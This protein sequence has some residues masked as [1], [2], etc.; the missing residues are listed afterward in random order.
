MKICLVVA[1]S[2][3]TGV[4]SVVFSLARGLRHAGVQVTVVLLSEGP[5]AD[6][7]CAYAIDT[8]VIPVRH[9][10]DILKTVALGRFFKT[11]K[12]D[13]I[14]A[15]GARASFFSSLAAV[16]CKASTLVATI[17]ELSDG[18]F[19]S[20]FVRS[21]ENAI[22]RWACKKY[23]AVSKSVEEDALAC[24][25]L[26][27]SKA[28]LIPNCLPDIFLERVSADCPGQK[29]Q[30]DTGMQDDLVVGIV[31]RLDVIKGHKYIIQ[32]WPSVML[33]FPSAQ[34]KVAGTGPL[35]HELE[36]LSLS[37][38]IRPMV[39]FL[40]S[41]EDMVQFY[42]TINLLVVPSLSESFGMTILEAM[43]CGV[44]VIASDVGGVSEIV[45]HEWNGLLVAGESP[46]AL[47]Q[48][49][50]RL[51]SDHNLRRGIISNGLTTVGPYKED[52]FIHRHMELY[53]SLIQGN[54]LEK[55]PEMRWGR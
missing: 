25:G 4:E 48:A 52:A 36:K 23:V 10:F 20:A 19:R 47:A 12:F 50:L 15:H 5:F 28:A 13:V 11:E 31:G 29:L 51:C 37:L 2:G 30:D 40:G 33:A 34:L 26:S 17:H 24:R 1:T 44:P 22:Y 21:L 16:S 8:R 55:E 43:A 42:R 45:I 32:A 27:Q 9:K 14:H 35:H 53:K 18:T 38:G 7:L 6:L 3:R 49:I 54:T 46:D 39:Q 41:I